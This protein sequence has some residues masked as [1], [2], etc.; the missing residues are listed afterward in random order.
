MQLYIDNKT[1]YL[2][3]YYFQTLCLLYYPGEK[4]PAESDSENKAV[5]SLW[6]ENDI[7]FAKVNLFADGREGAGFFSAGCEI[8]NGGSKESAA[9]AVVG[10][11]YLKAGKELFGFLPP[12]GSLT[13]LRPVKRAGYYLSKGFD[14]E[15]VLDLFSKAYN[16]SEEKAN[17]SVDIAKREFTTT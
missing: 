16:V 11:A 10:N 15:Y 12:W 4:F 9:E 1:E 13:G 17:L 8:I 5:F 7:I 2:N 3:N 6:E 14:R